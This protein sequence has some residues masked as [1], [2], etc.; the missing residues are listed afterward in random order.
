MPMNDLSVMVWS[1]VAPYSD[2]TQAWHSLGNHSCTSK[3]TI[4]FVDNCM[5]NNNKYYGLARYAGY[6][7]CSINQA[8]L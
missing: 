8:D 3:A 6:I 7:L 5:S 1:T 4:I 2:A